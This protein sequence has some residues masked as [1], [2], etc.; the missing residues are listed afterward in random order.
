MNYASFNFWKMGEAGR[1]H[2]LSRKGVIWLR[3]RSE[4]L[5]CSVHTR[6]ELHLRQPIRLIFATFMWMGEKGCDIS[7]CLPIQESSPLLWGRSQANGFSSPALELSF[8]YI[9][10]FYCSITREV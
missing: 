7:G 1:L 8:T 3:N 5:N 6:T 10:Q 2:M 4:R 9:Y